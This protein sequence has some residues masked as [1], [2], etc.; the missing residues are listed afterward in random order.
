LQVPR[1]LQGQL[2]QPDLRGQLDQPGRP[3]L[4]VQMGRPGLQDH[5][6]P[7]VLRGRPGLLGLPERQGLP[8]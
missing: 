5:L 6:V 3:A 4:L 1:D 2:V 8:V 7:Q